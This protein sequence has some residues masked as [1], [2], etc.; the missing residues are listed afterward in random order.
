MRH[1]DIVQIV[2]GVDVLNQKEDFQ[3]DKPQLQG[4]RQQPA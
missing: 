1:S 3:E 2:V 4:A